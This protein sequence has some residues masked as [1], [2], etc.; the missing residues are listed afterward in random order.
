MKLSC[1]RPGDS[2]TPGN[3]ASSVGWCTVKLG[4][5]PGTGAAGEDDVPWRKAARAEE[6]GNLQNQ[7]SLLC[8]SPSAKREEM[9]FPSLRGQQEKVRRTSGSQSVRL[10]LLLGMRNIL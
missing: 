8:Y 3:K 9:S 5:E 10:V 6:Q 1:L 2:H 7:T 4:L